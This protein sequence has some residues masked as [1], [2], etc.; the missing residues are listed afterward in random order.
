MGDLKHGGGWREGL[1]RLET[2]YIGKLPLPFARGMAGFKNKPFH[3]ERNIISP[4]IDLQRKIFPWIESVYGVNVCTREM[5]EYDDNYDD[6]EE[7]EHSQMNVVE[8]DGQGGSKAQVEKTHEPAQVTAADINKRG[9]LKLLVRLRRVILQDAAAMLFLNRPNK[10][11]EDAIFS[12][13]EFLAFK[14]DVFSVLRNSDV[15]SRL[16]E[17]EGLVPEIINAQR[18]LSGSTLQINNQILRTNQHFDKQFAFMMH[19]I[20]S[21]H[22]QEVEAK[23]HH[24]SLLNALSFQLQ[25]QDQ[26]IKQ[27]QAMIQTMLTS[28]QFLTS[29]LQLALAGQGSNYGSSAFVSSPS[30]ASASVPPASLLPTAL[31]SAS[32]PPAFVPF[33]SVPSAFVPSASVPFVPAPPSRPL[34]PLHIRPTP[35]LM[36][37]NR[38][39]K[40]KGKAKDI[41][42]IPYQPEP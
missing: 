26:Q 18:E 40:G 15:P 8:E 2:N 24:N 23:S 37:K 19:T 14:E 17:F 5:N 41:S 6:G 38:R 34:T 11:L 42:F 16:Q 33:A 4:S 27:Q 9:F 39:T 12:T 21:N 32:M 25:Q 36:A 10:L 3:L 1:S 20:N 35:P 31:P 13:P 29:Q 28:Q 30:A 7:P 22:K